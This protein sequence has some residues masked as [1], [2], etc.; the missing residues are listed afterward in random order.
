MLVQSLD[1]SISTELSTYYIIDSVSVLVSISSNIIRIHNLSGNSFNDVIYEDDLLFKP[2]AIETYHTESHGDLLILLSDTSL[3]TV[4]RWSSQLA[5]F[6]PVSTHDLGQAD[7]EDI[8]NYPTS[9]K[10]A[11]D[12]DYRCIAALIGPNGKDLAILSTATLLGGSSAPEA[13]IYNLP[14]QGIY[15]PRDIAMIHSSLHPTVA[16][17]SEAVPSAVYLQ[18]SYEYS[19][20]VALLGCPLPI[21]FETPAPLLTDL[22]NFANLPTSSFSLYTVGKNLVIFSPD[23][24][25]FIAE[26]QTRIRCINLN[27]FSKISPNFATSQSKLS[28]RLESL[29]CIPISPIHLLIVNNQDRNLYLLN[30]GSTTQDLV[31]CY[32]HDGPVDGISWSSSMSQICLTSLKSTSVLLDVIWNVDRSSLDSS[33]SKIKQGIVDPSLLPFS[34]TF[35]L[36]RVIPGLSIEVPEKIED[37]E[38][39]EI[40]REDAHTVISPVNIVLN[41][42]LAL[43]SKIVASEQCPDPVLTAQKRP[44]AVNVNSFNLDNEEVLERLPLILTSILPTDNSTRV[45]TSY[46]PELT[47]KRDFSLKT[48]YSEVFSLGPKIFLATGERTTLFSVGKGSNI[49][50]SNFSFR[51]KVDKVCSF[52]HS[53]STLKFAALSGDN[54]HVYAVDRKGENP[55][56]SILAHHSFDNPIDLIYKDKTLYV[57]FSN[58]ITRFDDNF[59]QKGTL[60]CPNIK[61][62]DFTGELMIWTDGTRIYEKYGEFITTYFCNENLPTS[63]ST[64]KID[65]IRILKIN[66]LYSGGQHYLLLKNESGLA[67]LYVRSDSTISNSPWLRFGKAIITDNL[68]SNL[69][70]CPLTQHSNDNIFYI[71]YSS[72][73]IICSENLPPRIHQICFDNKQV[74]A[75]FVNISSRYIDVIYSDGRQ[76]YHG[77]IRPNYLALDKSL[78]SIQTEYRKLPTITKVL[79]YQVS[80]FTYHPPSGYHVFIKAKSTPIK[81]GDYK[82]PILFPKDNSSQINLDRR[83]QLQAE[84]DPIQKPADKG[85]PLFL[86]K[87]VYEIILYDL[88]SYTIIDSYP[89][90]PAD[91]PGHESLTS[92]ISCPLISNYP[93]IYG[94]LWAPV[95]PERQE[96]GSLDMRNRSGTARDADRRAKHKSVA[97]KRMT[98]RTKCVFCVTTAFHML[99]GERAQNRGR[100]LIFD[101]EVMTNY[102]TEIIRRL[103]IGDNNPVSKHQFNNQVSEVK[104]RLLVRKDHGFGPPTGAV[105]LS[106]HKCVAILSGQRMMVYELLDA[107]DVLPCSFYDPVMIPTLCKQCGDFLTISETCGLTHLINF[108]PEGNRLSLLASHES[109]SIPRSTDFILYNNQMVLATIDN[110][111]NLRALNYNLESE[112]KEIRTTLLSYFDVRLHK[113][114][115]PGSSLRLRYRAPAGQQGGPY[116]ASCFTTYDGSILQTAILP[117]KNI[118]IPLLLLSQGVENARNNMTGVNPTEART[119]VASR[120]TLEVANGGWVDDRVLEQYLHLN[121]TSQVAIAN[122]LNMHV[123]DI[124]K[125]ILQARSCAFVF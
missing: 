15:N 95:E 86:N 84:I 97:K 35:P 66:L 79:D 114:V 43:S 108:S 124:P 7:F 55:S 67:S 82:M 57:V 25:C 13:I 46:F 51:G 92:V 18:K 91:I 106:R 21:S 77:V 31:S 81:A 109:A 115:V 12:P 85:Q 2:I 6:V 17:L 44:V 83:A 14:S 125:L 28:L 107:S 65:P 117:F 118:H 112:N 47:T 33:S 96:D 74:S 26:N 45:N 41:R 98:S 30:L 62:A 121:Y 1:E 113:E 24:I 56:V 40:E 120:R 103:E 100:V 69:V 32:T 42:V 19:C 105:A 90:E 52:D 99:Q 116:V 36:L 73:I 89:L 10:L 59:D 72:T 37:D 111:T 9:L 102:T 80:L 27:W 8:V 63:L 71:P 29:R 53:G 38:V 58:S 5:R 22:G 75:A 123:K 119:I 94:E 104:I 34:T 54:M 3:L 39:E 78:K 64:S 48:K 20:Y 16:V 4:S 61:A 122:S 23:S 70:T 60:T 88:A 87:F 101:V 68:K 110:Y 49:I 76:L 50:P 93:E 11:V